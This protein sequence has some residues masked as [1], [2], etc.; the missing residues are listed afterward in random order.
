MGQNPAY[1]VAMRNATGPEGT[2][3]NPR[4]GVPVRFSR[5]HLFLLLSRVSAH[6]V[7]HHHLTPFPPHAVR[8]SKIV[9]ALTP[10]MPHERA[11]PKNK[12]ALIMLQA[13]GHH[14]PGTLL[15]PPKK[16]ACPLRR[17][18]FLESR[19]YFTL[20]TR[21]FCVGYLV[22]IEWAFRGCLLC[23]YGREHLYS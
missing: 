21:S 9:S 14:P 12:D 6:L 16:Y 23:Q 20:K 18:A 3:G 10:M 1:S 19:K 17:G 5:P 8:L 15:R 4:V 2:G 13:E 22:G 7:S 11:H